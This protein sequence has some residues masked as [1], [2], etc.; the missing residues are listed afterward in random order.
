MKMGL[1]SHSHVGML[2]QKQAKESKRY[3][4][5]SFGQTQKQVKESKR[6]FPPFDTPTP[7]SGFLHMRKNT[8]YETIL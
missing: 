7:S 6:C 1:D 8:K 3:F 4:Q 2:T 5:S